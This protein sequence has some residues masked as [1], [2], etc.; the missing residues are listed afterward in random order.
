[1]AAHLENMLLYARSFLGV[2]YIYGGNTRQGI[3]CSGFVCA[4]LRSRGLVG[5]K[6]D[7]SAHGLYDKF[8][9]K[10]T[11]TPFSNWNHMPAGALIFYNKGGPR[12]VHVAIVLDKYAVI[13][14]GGGDETCTTLERAYALN[15]CVRERAAVDRLDVGAIVEPRYPW[16]S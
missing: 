13:E 6:E 4:V 16:L 10:G 1:M 15:A 9:A 11:F 12:M 14:A 8:K 7:L 2:P 5:L 3:D